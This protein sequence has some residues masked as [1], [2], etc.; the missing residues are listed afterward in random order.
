M[1]YFNG[2][3]KGMTWYILSCSV[4]FKGLQAGI[5]TCAQCLLYRVKLNSKIS[6]TIDVSFQCIRPPLQQYTDVHE[7]EVMRALQFRILA[8]IP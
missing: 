2:F 1:H 7:E 5:Q 6:D 3:F 4:T 8:G